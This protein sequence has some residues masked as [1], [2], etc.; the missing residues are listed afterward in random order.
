[1][2]TTTASARL[3]LL[4]LS[5]RTAPIALREQ[6]SCSLANLPSNWQ[7]LDNRFATIQE[8][9]ILSTCNRT[10]L[11]AR[12]NCPGLDAQ[13]L[14]ADLLARIKGV[15][16]ASFAEHLYLHVGLPAAEHLCRVAAGL[17]SQVLVEPQILG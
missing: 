7:A 1:M 16:K 5:Y 13:A 12:V 10:E 2:E 15:D 4:G 6:L 14:L 17:D 3:V 9:A 11:I 8:L